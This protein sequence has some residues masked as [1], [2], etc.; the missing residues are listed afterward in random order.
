MYG[1]GLTRSAFEQGNEA[2]RFERRKEYYPP[3][4]GASRAI[5]AGPNYAPNRVRDREEICCVPLAGG[6]YFW[7]SGAA[8]A[9]ADRAAAWP[10]P[11]NR[12]YSEPAQSRIPE[13]A[14][15]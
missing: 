10:A 4:R 9:G 11:L 12:S 7:A 8:L 15:F 14:S 13:F 1:R 3:G 2:E 6:V 5:Y